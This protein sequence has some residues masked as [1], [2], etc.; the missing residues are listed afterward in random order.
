MGSLLLGFFGG[1]GGSYWMV[2]EMNVQEQEIP[3]TAAYVEE[4]QMIDAQQEVAPAVVSIVEYIT[5]EQLREEYFGGPFGSSVPLSEYDPDRDGLTEIGGGTGFI[6]DPSGIV[7]TN[8]HVVADESGQYVAILN[9]GTEFDVVVEARDPGNDIAILQLKAKEGSGGAELLGSLPY[10]SLGDSSALQVGQRVLAIGNALAEYENTT[11]S[12]IIS[13]T[14]RKIVASDFSGKSSSLYGL[15]QTDAA[16]NPGNSGG[17]LIN[18]AGEVIGINTAIDT[19]AQGIGFAIPINDV[20]PAIESWQANGEILRPMLGVRYVMLTA[21]RAYELGFDVTH[22]ALVIGD[23]SSDEV[24][25]I[26][27]SPADQAGL[28]PQDVILQIDGEDIDLDYTLQD[29]IMR[30]QVGD[31]IT[32]TVWRDGETFDVQVELIKLELPE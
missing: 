5:L 13:A 8:K 31:E 15:L 28:V 17:P 14:G 22:G 9:D 30:Y 3:T 16:I 25:V 20:K 27:G 29:A 23:P 32:L 12:G 18:L 26:E 11:T 4:S 21:A 6:I 1:V 19:E 10:A 2:Q 7:L 24:A